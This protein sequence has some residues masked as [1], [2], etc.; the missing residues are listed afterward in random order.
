MKIFVYEFF[1]GGGLVGEPLPASLA[2]EGD[3]MLRA[4]LR[5]LGGVPGVEVLISRDSRLPAIPGVPSVMTSP[6]ESGFA[7]FAHGVEATD[8][9]W[10]IGPETGGVLERL[11][12]KVIERGRVLLGCLPEAVR[13]T[14]SKSATAEALREA[15]IPV[16]LTITRA[17]DLPAYPGRWV[18]KPDDGA[19]CDGALLLEGWRAARNYLEAA[20]GNLV[21]QPWVEGDAQSLSLLCADQQAFLLCCNRQRVRIR[22]AR[23]ALEGISVNAVGDQARR[24]ARL[25]ERIAATIPGLWGYVGV[26]LIGTAS[27]PVV[28]EINPRLTTSYCGLGQALGINAAAMVLDLL[29]PGGPKSRGVPPM[30]MTSEVALE[31]PHVS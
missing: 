22:N 26:D 9:T 7:L 31:A 5:D 2:R 11:T 23:L 28:L 25:G 18:V 6:G 16:V 30:G 29:A 14:A 13:L 27:G 21:A 24:L 17:A 8:A 1:T 4:L 15:G 10:P 3:L 19:G 12:R 20:P